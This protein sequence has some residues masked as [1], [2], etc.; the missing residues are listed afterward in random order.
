MGKE[1]KKPSGKLAGAGDGALRRRVPVPAPRPPE[2]P[3][4]EL[5]ISGP[6]FIG[7]VCGEGTGQTK[8]WQ[9]RNSAAGTLVSFLTKRVLVECFCFQLNGSCP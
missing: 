9:E 5:I 6:T 3:R 2:I 8:D 1:G 4:A 7:G